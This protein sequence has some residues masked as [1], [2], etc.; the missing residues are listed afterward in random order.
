MTELHAG[1]YV[2]MDTNH[3]DLIP[4]SFDVAMHVHATVTSRRGG[5]AVLDSGRKAVSSDAAMPAVA[6]GQIATRFVAEEH[7]GIRLPGDSTLRRGDRVLVVAGYAPTTVNLYGVLFVS[8]GGMV[9]DAWP[10]RA[11]H[12]TA[13]AM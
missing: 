9:V 5:N 6:G 2:V 1:S 11:R 7:M 13:D 10:I 8:S 4:G 12:G 3:G